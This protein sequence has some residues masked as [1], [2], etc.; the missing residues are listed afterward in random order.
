MDAGFNCI[1]TSCGQPVKYGGMDGKGSRGCPGGFVGVG[2]LCFKFPI[3][4]PA[5]HSDMAETCKN[6]DAIPYAPINLVQ[7]VVLKGLAKITVR[8]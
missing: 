5:V 4:E 2:T 7:N 6:L 1:D 3:Q 8:N